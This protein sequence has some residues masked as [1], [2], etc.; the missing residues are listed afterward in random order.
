MRRSRLGQHIPMVL[1][2]DIRI[3]SP[4]LTNKRRGTPSRTRYPYEPIR[5]RRAAGRQ[6]VCRHSAD[7]SGFGGSSNFIDFI[8]ERGGTRTLEPH[9]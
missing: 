2:T 6:L 3:L 8:G 7:T 5:I 4:C 1:R 9:D